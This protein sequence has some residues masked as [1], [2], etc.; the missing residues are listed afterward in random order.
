MQP[1]DSTPIRS[2]QMN[3]LSFI[4]LFLMRIGVNLADTDAM[5]KRFKHVY[6]CDASVGENYGDCA[7]MNIQAIQ[8]LTDVINDLGYAYICPPDNIFRSSFK[9]CTYTKSVDLMRSNGDVNTQTLQTAYMKFACPKCPEQHPCPSSTI[10]NFIGGEIDNK[11]RWGAFVGRSFSTIIVL[12]L[13]VIMIKRMCA[14]FFT[15]QGIRSL[16][17]VL[18]SIEEIALRGV[19]YVWEVS[20]IAW[21]QSQELVSR[22]PRDNT[23]QLQSPIDCEMSMDLLPEHDDNNHSVPE[24]I[25]GIANNVKPTINIDAI[26]TC[27]AVVRLWHQGF[28]ASVTAKANWIASNCYKLPSKKCN[29]PHLEKAC[30]YL[31]LSTN[32][33]LASRMEQEVKD[34][35]ESTM[36]HHGIHSGIVQ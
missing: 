33:K 1:E 31:G 10:N 36:R 12:L 23:T 30:A 5:L 15:L 14:L 4:V 34:A 25:D 13:T 22:R 7:K 24:Q 35:F 29:K 27:H 18:T 16:I 26:R 17:S 9:P 11:V 20:T 8:N 19:C 32:D 21:H 28:D 6:V 2:A 3:V